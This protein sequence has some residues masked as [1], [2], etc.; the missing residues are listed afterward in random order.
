MQEKEFYE[1][2]FEDVTNFEGIVTSFRRK[3]SSLC[4]EFLK[5]DKKS[6]HHEMEAHTEI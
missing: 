4:Y 1:N 6:P 2:G 3:V 5:N